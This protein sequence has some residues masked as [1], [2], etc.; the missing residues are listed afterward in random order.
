MYATVA[1]MRDKFGER[2]LI[3][4][5]DTEAPYAVI[6]HAIMRSLVI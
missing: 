5:T 1:A 6:W 4:L 2:E 3:Q